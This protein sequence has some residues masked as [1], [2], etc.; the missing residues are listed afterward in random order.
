MTSVFPF[1]LSIFHRCSPSGI[2][3]KVPDILKLQHTWYSYLYYS[4]NIM[5]YIVTVSISFLFN[6]LFQQSL[7][8]SLPKKM[9]TT[10]FPN[11]DMVINLKIYNPVASR[12][13]QNKVQKG[14]AP[15]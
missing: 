12:C 13:V 8:S 6:S 2:N 3:S 7:L 5:K 11:D 1:L 10:E 4:L 15:I 14:Q 9:M